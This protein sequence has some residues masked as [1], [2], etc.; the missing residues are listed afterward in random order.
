M[1]GAGKCGQ[2]VKVVGDDLYAVNVDSTVRSVG[3]LIKDY[4]NGEMPGILCE[5]GFYETD[6]FDGVITAGA[7]LKVAAT[8][9]L[10][11]GI[12]VGD[13]VVAQA[14]SVCSGTLKFRLLI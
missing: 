14:M 6:V 12:G 7:D 9:H 5:G 11:A 2:F 4:A 8:G 3:V 1:Q 10:S 13:V